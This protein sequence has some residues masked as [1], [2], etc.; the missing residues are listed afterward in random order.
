MKGPLRHCLPEVPIARGDR[1]LEIGSGHAPSQRADVLCD[2]YL[3]TKERP[4]DKLVVDRPLVIADAH[5]LPFKSKSFDYI[6]C[7]H[8]LEHAEDPKQF[9]AELE[10][11]GK[12]GYIETPS[13][14]AEN[15]FYFEYH[16]W[17]LVIRDETLILKRKVPGVIWSGNLFHHLFQTDKAFRFFFHSHP[18]MFRIKY[19][20]RDHIDAMIV[21]Q[22]TNTMPELEDWE[23]LKGFT[24]EP[25]NLIK[26]A[27]RAAVLALPSLCIRGLKWIRTAVLQLHQ[28]LNRRR[29]V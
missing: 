1:V 5:N 15:L 14:I 3:H 7:S 23:F 10:R 26:M 9:L 21:E 2:K 25:F 27:K 4:E 24:R 19:Y 18:D 20:W 13:E 6:I 28:P 17:S 11:V 12:A 16:R 22:G 8:V 29:G